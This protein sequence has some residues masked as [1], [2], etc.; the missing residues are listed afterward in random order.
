MQRLLNARTKKTRKHRIF[1]LP[2]LLKDDDDINWKYFSN[3]SQIETRD[4]LPEKFEQEENY[5][6]KNLKMYHILMWIVKYFNWDSK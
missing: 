6:T 2:I 3:R 5:Q 1:Y 4:N